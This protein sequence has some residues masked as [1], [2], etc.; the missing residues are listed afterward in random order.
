MAGINRHVAG[1]IHVIGGGPA[2]RRRRS[3]GPGIH[4]Q[5]NRIGI[6]GRSHA[7]RSEKQGTA[8][9]INGGALGGGSGPILPQIQ[10]L[11]QDHAALFNVHDPLPVTGNPQGAG[12]VHESILLDSERRRPVVFI[13]AD[14]TSSR[15]GSAGIQ[16]PGS[17]RIRTRHQSIASRYID[18]TL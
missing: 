3:Q 13:T 11:S 16:R 15:Q 5:D 18:I 7:S 12:N 1:K 14:E 17:S 9:Q 8:I 4:V 2:F 10:R 6:A